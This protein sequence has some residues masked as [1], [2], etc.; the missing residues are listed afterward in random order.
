MLHAVIAKAEKK[1]DKNR[2]IRTPPCFDAAYKTDC[3]PGKYSVKECM[4][5]ETSVAVSAVTDTVN[6]AA[7]EAAVIFLPV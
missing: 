4:S 7:G 6:P 3:Y 1:T 5:T 2:F